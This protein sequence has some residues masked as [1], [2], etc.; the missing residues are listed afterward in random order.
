LGVDEDGEPVWL[1]LHCDQSHHLVIDGGDRASR[2]AI[3]RAA[4]I[5]AALKTRPAQLQ[6][7]GID[8]SGRELTV[9]ETLPHAVTETA[10]DRAS[11]RASLLWLTADL[12]ARMREGRRWP[13]MLLVIDDVESLAGG[14]S[15]RSRASLTRLIR[16]GGRW[17]IHVAAGAGGS[18]GRLRSAAWSRADVARLTVA[19]PPGW[20]ELALGG[21]ATRLVGVQ[22]SASDLDAVANR[23]RPR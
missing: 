1:D 23:F 12:E 10:V 18:A 3:L 7:L 6:V 20:Y 17:G 19:E 16:S 14:D 11:A 2:S 4:A 22:L 13:D 21:R 15:G 5:G 8:A 9:L